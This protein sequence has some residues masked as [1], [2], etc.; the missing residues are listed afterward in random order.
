MMSVWTGA[1]L[2]GGAG[3][4]SGLIG[5][6]ASTEA[7]NTQS[8]SAN[9]ATQA[10]LGMFNQTQANL[11]PWMQAGTQSLAQLQAA[12]G[13]PGAT[14]PGGV[15]RHGPAVPGVPAGTN[16]TSILQNTPGYQWTV[17]QGQ[18]SILDQA[19]A[20]GGTNSGATLKALSD[21]TSNQ[22][23]TTY[24]QYIQNLM[25][26]SG[27]GQNAAANLGGFAASTGSQIGSNLIG[28]GNAQAAGQ[29]GTAS[30]LTGGA[31]SAF[32]NY[33]LMSMLQNNPY[34]GGGGS[35]YM[36]QMQQQAPLS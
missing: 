27:A 16:L 7:A 25:S 18:Q 1:L 4:I 33:L 30:A 23:N 15:A 11:Q 5:A 29:I 3:I 36:G 19:S 13:M 14:T 24:E 31:N 8:S 17:G 28:S 26:Q 9:A 6:N 20:L 2:L 21:Y 12:L 22:A 32:N 34:L 10:E 35:N